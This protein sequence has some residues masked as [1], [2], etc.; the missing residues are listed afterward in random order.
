MWAPLGKCLHFHK[1][2]SDSHYALTYSG[3]RGS[4]RWRCN[5]TF[6]F[7][8]SLSAALGESPN[9]IPWCYL[10]IPST[11]FLSFLLLSLSS[12]ELSLP[13][14]RILRCGH[15]I[16][17]SVSLP[18]LEGHHALQLHSGFCCKSLRSSHGLCRK[19]SEVYSI[20]SRGLGSFF[21][22][23]L[24]RSGSQRHKERVDKM[25][26]R[27]SLNLEA[28]E[29]FLSLHMILG[30]ERAAAVWAILERISGFDP[31][32]EMIA[33]RYLKFTAS[34]LR[35]FY[36]DLSFEAIWV[37]CHHFP[38]SNLHFVPSDDCI[39]TAK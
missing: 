38:F 14:Q 9:T 2:C 30:L 27:I 12:A 4:H 5:N 19:C 10:P 28:R 15:T 3:H 17:I 33:P 23:L 26:V 6:P 1:K 31:S 34:S 39:E 24:S 21:W 36:L 37:V 20:S 32:L 11:V 7:L 16:W 8:L 29:M 35:P 18:W 22:V 25:S 13:C